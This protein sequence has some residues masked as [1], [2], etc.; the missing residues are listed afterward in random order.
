[1]FLMQANKAMFDTAREALS[2][3]MKLLPFSV[4]LDEEAEIADII[5]TLVGDLPADIT[6]AHSLALCFDDRSKVPPQV[7]IYVLTMVFCR[8]C[9]RMVCWCELV[10]VM[11]YSCC[12]IV[13]NAL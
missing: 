9:C 1:M 13:K 3:A 11:I 5:L 12:S 7:K 6:L 4:F 2:W 8:A 10:I